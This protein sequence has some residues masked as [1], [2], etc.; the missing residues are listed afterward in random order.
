MSI[1]EKKDIF[2]CFCKLRY[3]SKTCFRVNLI[4]FPFFSIN[5]I[6]IF[7]R[8][9]SVSCHDHTMLRFKDIVH[10][11]LEFTVFSRQRYARIT[12]VKVHNRIY[13]RNEGKAANRSNC[14][15]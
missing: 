4:E 11:H 6:L 7:I 12:A 5:M 10:F 2:G 1:S 13:V 15:I 3:G 9:F 8:I 14:A